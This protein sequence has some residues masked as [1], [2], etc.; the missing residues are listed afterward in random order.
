MYLKSLT[1]KGFKSFASATT[2]N[3][4]PGITAIVG[5]NGSGKSNVVDALAWVMGEQGA[6]SLRGGKMEDVIFAGTTA[7]GPLGRAEVSLTIDNTDGLLPIEFT[8]VTISRTLFRTGG[9]E[10]AINGQTVRLLDVQEL[11]SDTGMGREMH[12]IVGQ[13]QLDQ[14]LQASPE[15]RR[16]FIEEAA[17]VLKH[18][19]RKDRA[20]RKL[21][22]TQTNL[23]RLTDLLTEIRRQLK[24]LGRQ[25]EVAR[26]AASVQTQLRDARARLLADDIT[27]A[28]AALESDRAAELALKAQRQRAEAE[29]AAAR[30]AEN[31]AEHAVE[32]LKPQITAAQENWYALSA[33][34]ERVNAT[35]QVAAERVRH[36][37]QQPVARSGRDPEALDREAEQVQAEEAELAEQV[38]LAE[39]ALATA[40]SRRVEAEQAE[41]LAARQYASQLRAIA[42]RREGLAKLTGQVNSLESR[43]EA[44]AEE[45]AR[46]ASRLA[47][48]I[49]RAED[50]EHQ[51]NQLEGRLTGVSA[52][53]SDL[54]AEYEQAAAAQ[55][56]AQAEL[57]GLQEQERATEQQMATLRARIDALRVG[58][59]RRDGSGALLAGDPVAGLLG[60][61]SDLLSVAPGWQTAVSAALG[62][63]IE[64]VALTDLPAALGAFERLKSEDLGRAV[65]L[66]GDAPV[67]DEA[68]PALPD[69]A[70]WAIDV[71]DA[72]PDVRPVLCR[73]LRLVAVVDDLTAA[74]SLVTTHPEV[75]AVTVDGDLISTWLVGGGSSNQPSLFEVQA[76]IDEASWQLTELSHAAERTRFAISA[77][78][79]RLSQAEQATGV[80]LERLHESDA[81][82]SALTEQ[83][84]SLAQA[85]R[86]ARAEAQRLEQAIAAAGSKRAADRAGLGELTER[87]QAASAATDL[88]E[89]DPTDRDRAAMLARQA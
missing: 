2:L 82:M 22:S 81:R 75:T 5:P 3:F 6:K 72:D 41:T 37:A 1:L 23:A 70:R 36:G 47:E 32:Q 86:N 8:E 42:D 50:A 13:G 83:L 74:Q 60:P 14:I 48:A 10:Y 45:E 88:N 35:R 56:D 38:R 62:A 44:S 46:L 43:L 24:P 9:S 77:V 79:Q 40:T 29:L 19:R 51:F 18:R 71:I 68:W 89:P 7:R 33:L 16:G 52:G 25:A 17:G 78:R 26:K 34:A 59:Q 76:S 67:L 61:L 54:D 66:L 87:L 55:A 58:L 57:V 27:Q 84:A 28:R 85:G 53:E 73:L 80:A 30:E 21:E 39:Q 15:A 65:M 49:S 4:E 69:D 31:A 64:A 12:V 20:V 11:L 63:A